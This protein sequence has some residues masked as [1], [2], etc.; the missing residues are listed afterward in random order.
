M[1]GFTHGITL[2]AAVLAAVAAG[3]AQAGNL[4]FGTTDGFES[5]SDQGEF[6]SNGGMFNVQPS[7]TNG[8]PASGGSFYA[9]IQPASPNTYMAGYQDGPYAHIGASQAYPSG[10]GDQYSIFT[11]IYTQATSTSS[12]FFWWTNGVNNNSTPDYTNAYLTESGFQITPGSSNW[13][14]TTTAGGHPSIDLAANS[15][16]TMEVT[17]D[18]SGPTVQAILDIFNQGERTTGTALYSQTLDTGASSSLLGGPRYSW[19]TVWNNNAIGSLAIDNIGSAGLT[20]VPEPSN[21]AMVA[22]G[23]LSLL[24]VRLVRRRKETLLVS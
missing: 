22:G 16:Y 18:R 8:I 3:S 20:A 2:A 14:F 6:S 15:W 12:G 1:R 11:D 5:G 13:N 23:A 4:A 9:Q 24:G 19:F 7:G 21:L 17:F 10:A